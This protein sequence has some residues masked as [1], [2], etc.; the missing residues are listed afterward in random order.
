MKT[1]I[2][3]ITRSAPRLTTPTETVSMIMPC[4]RG[5]AWE[6]VEPR[7]V[8]LRKVIGSSIG[9]I[10]GHVL[11]LVCLLLG[12]EHHLLISPLCQLCVCSRI[13]VGVLLG[14]LCRGRVRRKSVEVIRRLL[15]LLLG[16]V[17]EK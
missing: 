2:L 4:R 3:L 11:H 10:A 6:R 17:W 16:R 14:Y 15:L 13:E 7:Y 5:A 8:I 9:T 1:T 12:T